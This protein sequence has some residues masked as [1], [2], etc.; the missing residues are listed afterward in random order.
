MLRTGLIEDLEKKVES[1]FLDSLD[2]QNTTPGEGRSIY[3]PYH[4]KFNKSDPKIVIDGEEQ[5]QDLMEVVGATMTGPNA[6]DNSV[7]AFHDNS[8]AIKGYE[9]KNLQ[10]VDPGQPCEMLPTDVHT[11]IT[12]TAETHN[13]P[14]GIAPF[15]GAATGIGGR[16]RDGHATGTG[17]HGGGRYRYR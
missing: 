17:F 6:N 14:T 4:D 12:F 9:T 13:F 11:H 5:T 10:P 2:S 16:I 15:P 1:S 7:I 3:N 8:S